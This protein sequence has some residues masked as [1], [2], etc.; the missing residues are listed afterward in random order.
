MVP[1]GAARR[2]RP[3][4]PSPAV[5]GAVARVPLRGPGRSGRGPGAG[6]GSCAAPSRALSAGSA[7]RRGGRMNRAGRRVV[8]CGGRRAAGTAGRRDGG[9]MGGR[10]RADGSCDS[11][12]RSPPGA[13]RG[14]AE[15]GRTAQGPGS[16]VAALLG[17]GAL[18]WGL[19]ERNSNSRNRFIA[20]TMGSGAGWGVSKVWRAPQGLASGGTSP[21]SGEAGEGGG[22]S[23]SPRCC[24]CRSLAR[25]ALEEK[26]PEHSG[27]GPWK[28]MPGLTGSARSGDR[29][30]PRPCVVIDGSDDPVLFI[31]EAAVYLLQLPA[32]GLLPSVNFRAW[33]PCC[34]LSA[35]LLY[36]LQSHT[37]F[38]LQGSRSNGGGEEHEH[39]VAWAQGPQRPK[40]WAVLKAVNQLLSWGGGYIPGHKARRG[41]ASVF[42]T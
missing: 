20:C 10:A 21:A 39:A 12:T 17:R 18:A 11:D 23:F 16:R 42:V 37:A 41:T 38:P 24:S 36:P 9:T 13:G 30:G 31:H 35:P 34:P 15:R 33:S 25:L 27:Q 6:S 4:C 2:R 40:S 26:A 8:R 3:H 1:V 7:A 14:G 29:P 5:R 22:E 32:R 28:V 19:K